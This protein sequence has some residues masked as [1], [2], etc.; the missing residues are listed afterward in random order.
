MIPSK[1]LL[2]MGS[3]MILGNH[4]RDMAI[5]AISAFMLHNDL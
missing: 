4:S 1:K 2:F 3:N 5:S